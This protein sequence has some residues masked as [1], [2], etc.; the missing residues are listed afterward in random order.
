MP[1]PEG[2]Q[3]T[4]S[5]SPML[6]NI[7]LGFLPKLAA[8]TD[9]GGMGF[10]A[11]Q[12]FPNVPVAAPAGQYYIWKRGDFLRRQMKK[13]ANYEAAPI[14]GFATGKG[15]YSVDKFGIATLYTAQDL[16]NARVGGATS[17]SFINAKNLLVT[18]TSLLE[19]EMQTADVIQTAAN[20]TFQITGVSSGPGAN[21]ILQWDQSASDPVADVDALRERMRL[22]SGYAPNTMILPIQ[23]FNALRKNVNLIDRI[24]YGGTMDRPTE[25]TLQQ[26]KALFRLNILIPEGVYNTAKEGAAD[27]FDY[28]YGKKVW[29][30]FVAPM[31]SSETPSAGY[32]FSW[33]GDVSAGLPAGLDPSGDGPQAFGSVRSSEGLFIR[34]YTENRPQGRFIES[35][36]FTTPN[37]VAADL[38]CLISA[39]IA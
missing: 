18:T 17:A 26:M 20:W 33:N 4:N 14:I 34:T 29:I 19:L 6:T 38:G 30:G 10:I 23:V 37:V 16:A 28:I 1:Q 7:A 25:V 35:E 31:P 2:V 15:S 13:L 32:H 8:P 12:V 9:Q 39:V 27:A 5:I 22:G 11:K 24:K 21:Q 36:L 3:L